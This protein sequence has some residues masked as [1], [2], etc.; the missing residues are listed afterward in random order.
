MKRPRITPCSQCTLDLLP[1]AASSVLDPVLKE[2]VLDALAELLME[3]LGTESGVNPDG[4]EDQD[5]PEAH[6]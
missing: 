4:K 2:E 3:A 6:A 5:E 1:Q